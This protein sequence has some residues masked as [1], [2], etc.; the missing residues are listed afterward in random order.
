MAGT[1]AGFLPVFIWFAVTL[2]FGNTR[3]GGSMYSWVLPA[4]FA[5]MLLVPPAYGYAILRHR[6]IPVSL[7]IR[8]GF[9][10]KRRLTDLMSI[11]WKNARRVAAN[12]YSSSMMSTLLD[13][14]IHQAKTIDIADAV[15]SQYVLA[16]R[17]DS[18]PLNGSIYYY[19][20]ISGYVSKSQS[21]KV[22]WISLR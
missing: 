6:V 13:K 3:V 18:Y 5:T 1:I 20:Q 17:S 8:L 12:Y 14:Q 11:R 19:R 7:I 4:V 10:Y 22:K 15:A 21:L 16:I 2:L 9:Q